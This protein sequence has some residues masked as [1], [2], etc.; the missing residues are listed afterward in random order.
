MITVIY[1]RFKYH[2]YR[3]KSATQLRKEREREKKKGVISK[4]GENL[5]FLSCTEYY[6][7]Y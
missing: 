2:A 6:V 7:E 1:Q 3:N 4:I 5:K